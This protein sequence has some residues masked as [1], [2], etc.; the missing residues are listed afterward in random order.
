MQ[1]IATGINALD[2][3]LCGGL[4]GNSI[5]LLRGGPG[6]G[7]TTLALQ[8]LNNHLNRI[9]KDGVGRVGVFVSLEEQ[10][11]DAIK[12][13]NNSFRFE[14]PL[15]EYAGGEGGSERLDFLTLNRS[16][17]KEDVSSG[18]FAKFIDRI[19]AFIT[20]RKFMLAGQLAM[21]ESKKSKPERKPIDRDK[22]KVPIQ[23]VIVIDS[24]NALL[25]LLE[26]YPPADAAGSR[27][28]GNSENE[29]LDAGLSAPD[30][31]GE[32]GQD[33]SRGEEA[34]E[35]LNSQEQPLRQH[36]HH[37][38]TTLRMVADQ[39]QRLLQRNATIILIGEHHSGTIAESVV[40]ESFVCDTEILL[41]LEAIAGE[42][43]AA[44]ADRN[45]L[46]YA[47]ERNLSYGFESKAQHATEMRPFCRI[48]KSRHRKAQS[49]RCAY[50]VVPHHGFCFFETFPGDGEMML[51]YENPLQAKVWDE[52][53]RNDIPYNY[54]GL[55]FSIFDRTRLQL[56][57]ATQ[58]HSFDLPASTDMSLF[59]FDTYWIQWYRDLKQRNTIYHSLLAHF[60]DLRPEIPGSQEFLVDEDRRTRESNDRIRSYI[61]A[62]LITAIHNLTIT[63]IPY[64]QAERR[65]D[66]DRKNRLAV[67]VV[68]G[69]REDLRRAKGCTDQ[70]RT[71]GEKL[72]SNNYTGLVALTERLWGDLRRLQGQSGA[73][74]PLPENDLRLFGE[75]RSRIIR[76]L[77]KFSKRQGRP[78]HRIQHSHGLKRMPG[79][80]LSVPYNAN[81][82]F[83]VY[84]PESLEAMTHTDQNAYAESLKEVWRE[85]RERFRKNAERQKAWLSRLDQW[86]EQDDE[87]G[88][89]YPEPDETVC[90]MLV[91]E[92]VAGKAPSTWEQ[93]VALGRLN[94]Q[95]RKM[96]IETRSFDSFS[97]TL[98]EILW[99]T[100]CDL[101]V[102]S[103]YRIEHLP[104][105]AQRLFQA[106]ELI[107]V[108]FADGTIPRN[109]SVEI[110]FL[111]GF[112]RE[113]SRT[114]SED[115][116]AARFWHST[117]IEALTQR[118]DDN[119]FKWA[120][121]KDRL[122]VG[123]IPVTIDAY[124][125]SR[126]KD[127]DAGSLEGYSP[128]HH[129]CWGEWHFGVLMGSE[130]KALAVEIINHF[131]SSQKVCE[132]ASEHAIIPTVE[133]FYRNYG[134]Q[135]C[136]DIASRNV[137]QLP[138]LTFS[139]LRETYF[140]DARS[141]SQIF[142]YRHCMREI[143][144]ILEYIRHSP[145]KAEKDLSKRVLRSLLTI[146]DFRNRL[147]FLH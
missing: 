47:I 121:C 42:F 68:D 125:G 24:L 48:L 11:E 90:R 86:T 124:V 147:L 14:L 33:I 132:M 120:S 12:H 54:P 103:Q 45:P 71:F 84:R 138:Q 78:I 126:K 130:N 93:I 131:M 119:S 70:E 91:A 106:L 18:K 135:P 50:D 75:R 19:D 116:Y 74:L 146:R 22:I 38:R 100:G 85:Q 52:F 94:P 37:M 92:V 69:L 109:S 2:D 101:S 98:L 36:R 26:E 136:I 27:A 113:K 8:I 44:P 89:E 96:L 53:L 15:K 13:V 79:V 128:T 80:L 5:V 110:D 39:I 117:L 4:E 59:C 62:N 88:F 21:E 43:K 127:G 97:T 60:E 143:H 83:L 139:E 58:R 104:K 118:T 66:T 112:P 122:R 87:H 65:E 17:T 41:T 34:P 31:L 7:K 67:G 51:F 63:P 111:Q 108:M 30:Q 140:A 56:T 141:R 144:S 77:E 28:P 105:V 32:C 3:M 81:I 134:D 23:V 115:W 73:L 107:R 133:S 49:R 6:S 29:D 1:T 102:D 95:R 114:E 64:S 142:D 72:F 55:R 9:T 16:D 10:P 35:A 137:P 57:F 61:L 20:H 99:G 76:E 46:G 129:S 25:G 82:S 145:S 123:R 40:A